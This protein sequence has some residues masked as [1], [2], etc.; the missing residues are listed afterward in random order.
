MWKLYMDPGPMHSVTR[1]K[2]LV[3]IVEHMLNKCAAADVHIY[4]EV[5]L[6]GILF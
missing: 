1:I 4:L 6:S 3:F 5:K 2:T